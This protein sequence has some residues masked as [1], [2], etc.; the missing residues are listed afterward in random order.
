MLE[1]E[2]LTKR[3]KEYNSLEKSELIDNLLFVEE[4]LNDLDGIAYCND[5][6]D[7]LNQGNITLTKLL[8]EYQVEKTKLEPIF[9]QQMEEMFKNL[10][11]KENG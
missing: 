11:N 8:I 10:K 7:E 5:W 9:Q 2:I 4:I 1:K 3:L 6:L